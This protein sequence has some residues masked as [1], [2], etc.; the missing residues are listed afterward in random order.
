[1]VILVKLKWFTVVDDINSDSMV[2]LVKLIWF[3]VV[4]DDTDD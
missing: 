4:D 3:A 2:P 1:M